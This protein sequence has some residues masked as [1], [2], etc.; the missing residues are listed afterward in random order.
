MYYYEYLLYPLTSPKPHYPLKNSI[1]DYEIAGDQ[2]GWIG[3]V[4]KP[5]SQDASYAVCMIDKTHTIKMNE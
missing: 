2:T 3:I 1:L 4:N 5:R